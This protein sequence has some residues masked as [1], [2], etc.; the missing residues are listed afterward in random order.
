MGRST[1]FS[2]GKNVAFSSLDATVQARLTRNASLNSFIQGEVI[3]SASLDA[4]TSLFTEYALGAAL[5]A[6]LIP[7]TTL[8]NGLISYWKFD[9]NSTDELGVGNGTDTAITYSVGNGKLVQGA[10]FNGSSSKVVLPQLA[11]YKPTNFTISAWVKTTASG[12]QEVFE[13]YNQSGTP[14]GF[15]FR[16]NGAGIE[17]VV[18][19][20]GAF[21]ITSGVRTI[22]NG[23]WNHV[24]GTYDGATVRLYV[25][26]LLDT[27]GANA[28]GVAYTGD[29][30][31]RI[32][33]NNYTGATETYW[34]NGAIDEVGFWNR[35]LTAAEVDE[36][37]N[38]GVGQQYPF[39]TPAPTTTGLL[40]YWKLDGGSADSLGVANG[41]DTAITY[42]AGNGKI[43]Q[44][45]GFNG[46]TSQIDAG[47]SLPLD[48][49]NWS[50]AVWM[51]PATASAARFL[52]Y[53]GSGPTLQWSTGNVALVHAG[54]L[55]WNPG[56]P[57]TSGVWTHLVMTRQNNQ[58][59]VYKNGAQLA[60]NSAFAASFTKDTTVRFGNSPYTS[61][62]LNGALD[63]IGIWNRRLTATEAAALYNL[64]SGIQYPF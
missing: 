46:T 59:I 11:A 16:Q 20:G 33:V 60:I 28:T 54:T 21:T 43:A 3:K 15:E 22:N 26:G 61:E 6:Y 55:D 42:S 49:N 38:K 12:Y 14:A 41:T 31:V 44:G 40:G 36:L 58:I 39:G 4:F 2:S 17:L 19:N 13:S 32:G 57:V 24:T 48:S 30:R 47:S 27:S 18:G 51:N 53:Y 25:N 9:G 63:E 37:Y 5:D 50:L 35:A 62:P 64:G 45:A 7:N 34:F 29:T 52:T 10:G 56:I 23:V 8:G 1:S